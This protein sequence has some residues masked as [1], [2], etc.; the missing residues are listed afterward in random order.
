MAKA[1]AR[2]DSTIAEAAVQ[3]AITSGGAIAP[4]STEAF[5]RL[6]QDAV[7]TYPVG[8]S[9]QLA[10]IAAIAELGTRYNSLHTPALAGLESIASW[11]PPPVPA[12]LAAAIERLR[13]PTARRS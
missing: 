2:G 8:L 7:V 12:A 4:T 3:A 9:E 1:H 10:A 5:S 13:Q 11:F 6:V